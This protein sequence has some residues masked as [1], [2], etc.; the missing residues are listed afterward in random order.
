MIY[1]LWMKK[2]SMKFSSESEVD[3]MCNKGHLVH[4]LYFVYVV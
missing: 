1:I 3:Y 2:C 4:D